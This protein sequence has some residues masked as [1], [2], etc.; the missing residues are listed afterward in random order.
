MNSI[1]LIYTLKLE[2]QSFQEIKDSY[3]QNSSKLQ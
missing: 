3:S 1:N 2:Q